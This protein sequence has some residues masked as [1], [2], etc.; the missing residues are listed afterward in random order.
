MRKHFQQQLSLGVT[1]I[2]EVEIYP[3]TRDHMANLLAALKYIFITPKW[4][5]Q[6]FKLL[7]ANIQSTKKKTGRNGMSLWEIFVLAQT[8]LCMNIGYDQLHNFSNYHILLRGI[9]GVQK[10]YFNEGKQY[11]YQNIYDNISL[12][13]DD[14]L[15]EINA[16]ILKVG[17]EIF[18]KKSSELSLKT[19]SFVVETATHFPTD[20]SLLWDSIRKSLDII[21]KLGLPKWRKSKDWRRKLKSLMREVGR[22]SS[23]GGQNK[24]ERLIKSAQT[25]LHKTN[26][27]KKKLEEVLNYEFTDLKK[28]E[29]Q[30]ELLYYHEMLLKHINLIERRLINCEKIPH[31]EKLISIFQPFV[32]MINKGKRNVEI[33]K[34]LVI[35]TEEN[36][37][38]VDW[39]ICTKKSDSEV[40]IP[41]IDRILSK[42]KIKRL[43]VDK[44]FSSKENKE[45]LSL[46]IEKV[47]MPKKG[48]LNKSEKE[49]ERETQFKKYRKKHSAIESNINELE[50]R[51]LN[52]C[53]DRKESNFN[54]YIGLACISYNLHKI[55]QY[56]S[57]KKAKS[58][59]TLKRSA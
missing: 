41:I 18:K 29:L 27:L 48:K 26:N 7:E 12:L 43:S 50:H 58:N 55:G 56:I 6:I 53:P 57:R 33:G 10:G 20:Y 38:I 40:L 24:E 14:L 17:H 2:S 4:N 19:D 37:L 34:K 31:S 22:I 3:N 59:I 30:I 15:K 11:T 35:T 46:Y 9:M 52:K 54:R 51:G 23:K 5:K 49:E 13:D 42:H 32:E 16:I 44:G 36:N 28:L 8:R 21:E 39:E 45:L 1:P 25:Y 47:I